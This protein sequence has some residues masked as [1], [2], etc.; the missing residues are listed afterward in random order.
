LALARLGK[1]ALTT[2]ERQWL[3]PN[4]SDGG[5][6]FISYNITNWIF[7]YDQ[8]QLRQGES[9]WI[10][11]AKYLG[12]SHIPHARFKGSVGRGKNYTLCDSTYDDFR[13]KMMPYSYEL[14][15]WLQKFFLPIARDASRADVF[16]ADVDNFTAIIKNYAL[17]PCQR[18]I[19][20]DNGTYILN[21]SF[22]GN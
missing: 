9:L 7:L 21:A 19:R 20:M 4:D 16:V 15:V 2:E 1:T 8:T 6:A 3:A 13:A 12:V 17:D 5:D 22:F 14:S 18:L 11:L 10:E